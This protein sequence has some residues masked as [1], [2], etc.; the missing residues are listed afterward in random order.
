[1]NQ[2]DDRVRA[3]ALQSGFREVFGQDPDGVWAAPGRVNLIGE[4]TD[5]NEGFVLP[6]ALPQST[7]VAARRRG[8][9]QVRVHSLFTEETAE[10]AL[11]GLRPGSVDGWAAYV[12]GMCWGLR[13]ADVAVVGVDLLIDSTVPHGAG[14]SSSAALECSVGLAVVELSGTVLEPL[15]LARI[16][17]LVENDFVGMPCGLMDQM[18]SMLGEAGHA[19]LFDTRSLTPTLVPLAPTGDAE[20]LVIDTRAPHRLVD[21]EYAER[22]RQCEEAADTLGVTSLRELSDTETEVAELLAPL[23]DETLR[24]RARHVITENRRVSE[25]VDLLRD[26]DLAGVGERMRGSHLSLRDDYE[27]TVP[28]IDLAFDVVSGAGVFGARITGG[29]FGGCVIALA[30]LGV[31]QQV[32]EAVTAA[33]AE[34]GFSAPAVFRAPPADGARRVL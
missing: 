28:E 29:G 24:H 20:V 31:H 1:M 23:T 7:Y 22:R 18:I 33:F 11:E 19:V 3:Q 17:Q 25:A 14:L 13:E 27:V 4:H 26:G 9:G 2:Q 32:E 15:A 12:A 10:F 21:G 6:F 16:A 30:P 34:V 5:Y 8:D